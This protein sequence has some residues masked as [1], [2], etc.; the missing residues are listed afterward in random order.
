MRNFIP[1]LLVLFNASTVLAQASPPEPST[2]SSQRVVVEAVN[3]TQPRLTTIPQ[4]AAPAA[5]MPATAGIGPSSNMPQPGDYGYSYISDL[6]QLN[7]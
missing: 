1:A 7:F 6:R 3:L 2:T 4:Q 5:V